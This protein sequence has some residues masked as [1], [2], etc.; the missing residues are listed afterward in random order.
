MVRQRF[1]VLGALNAVSH[2]MIAVT[3]DTYITAQSVCM[4]LEK[5]VFPAI[6][7]AQSQ[8]D[9]ESMQVCEKEMFV[10]ALPRKVSCFQRGYLKVPARNIDHL[11][12]CPGGL[13]QGIQF[14]FFVHSTFSD[15]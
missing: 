3:S 11:H 6:L 14:R 1:N 12:T 2:E 10:F 4:L 15:L 7:F 13:C 8:P 9:R 5:I